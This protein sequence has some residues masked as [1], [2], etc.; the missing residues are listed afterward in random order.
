ME[1]KQFVAKKDKYHE[2]NKTQHGA[3]VYNIVYH[4]LSAAVIIASQGC[5]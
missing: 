3:G 4:I 2:H 5:S 1:K